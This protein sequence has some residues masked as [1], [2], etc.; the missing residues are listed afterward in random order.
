VV[1]ANAGIAVAAMRNAAVAASILKF[2]KL[3]KMTPLWYY[4]IYPSL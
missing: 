1:V 4:T 2:H 3:N